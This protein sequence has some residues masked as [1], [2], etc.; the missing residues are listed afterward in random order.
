M[1]WNCLDVL[2]ESLP[3]IMD[4]IK[5]FESECIIVDNGSDDGTKEFLEKQ[6]YDNLIYNRNPINLGIS[7][8]KNIG[9]NLSK[10]EYILMLD[11]DIIPVKNSIKMFVEYLEDNPEC[12]ALGF[13]PNKWS[14][15]KNNKFGQTFHETELYELHGIEPINRCCIYYGIFRRSLFEKGLRLNEKG[16]F[17][18][19]GY[20][21]EDHDFFERMKS[22]GVTQYVANVN[23]PSGKYYHDINSSIRAMGRQ[24]YVRTSKMRNEE[25]KKEWNE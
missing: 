7:K 8:G 5:K 1:A 3:L 14:N 19:P 4:E 2:S 18:K 10:G 22:L 20:G 23:R 13:R 6:T 17:G 24:E 25:F 16:E 21:W 11:A 9:I 15:Q 12:D